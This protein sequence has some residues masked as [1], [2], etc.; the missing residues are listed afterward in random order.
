MKPAPI[1]AVFAALALASFVSIAHAQMSSSPDMGG[2]ARMLSFGIG[3]GVS[4]PVS[5]ASDAFKTGYNGQGFVRFNLK[6]L[7]IQPRIDF[8]F[9][10][11]DVASAKLA[12]PGASGTG[13]ILAGVANLQ[14]FVMPGPV[15]PYVVAGLGAYNFKTDLSGIP[16]AT[17]K[18]DTR[19]GVNGGLG[20]LVKLGSLVSGYVEGHLDNVFSQKG[21]VNSSQLQVIPV[22]VGV[23]Y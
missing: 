5:N 1:R 13:Q 12:A 19:F 8:T 4:V 16:G 3:G 6:A 9:S 17:S 2:S 23:V 14:Y 21:F 18:S 11:F 15:R 7:P 20:V 22:T 10:K